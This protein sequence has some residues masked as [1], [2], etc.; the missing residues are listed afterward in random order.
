MFMVLFQYLIFC[1]CVWFS[2]D[3]DSKAFDLNKQLKR[4]VESHKEKD[5]FVQ[6]RDFCKLYERMK[7]YKLKDDHGERSEDEDGFYKPVAYL[8]DLY[9]K[10]MLAWKEF[11]DACE[12]LRETFPRKDKILRLKEEIKDKTMSFKD[13]KKKEERRREFLKKLQNWAH[14]T[15]K[16][17]NR[18]RRF[19]KNNK[20]NNKNYKK[21]NYLKSSSSSSSSSSYD[22]NK[23]KFKRTSKRNKQ[24]RRILCHSNRIND[25]KHINTNLL[26]ALRQIENRND[27]N[28]NIKDKNITDKN[29]C[30]TD[31]THRNP[32]GFFASSSDV[33]T[34][35]GFLTSRILERI[36]D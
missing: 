5:D 2:M 24:L 34:Y 35:V 22:S 25:K 1:T 27:R 23:S 18:L 21:R 6:S 16:R 30:I 11:K 29:N 3:E 4:I 15:S 26:K 9:R 33:N 19:N 8:R 12:K 28:N 32:D 17:R 14:L 20:R 13:T 36:N 10:E 31:I 7:N